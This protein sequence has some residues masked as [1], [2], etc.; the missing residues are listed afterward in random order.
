MILWFP[1]N[2]PFYRDSNAVWESALLL[3][4]YQFNQMKQYFL[5]L[6]F[7][8]LSIFGICQSKKN[9][10]QKAPSQKEM[11]AMMEEAMKGMSA[12]EKAQ[13]KKMVGGMMTDMQA[14]PAAAVVTFNDNKSLIPVRN[15][16]A[17]KSISSKVFSNED[18]INNTKLLYAKLIMKMPSAEKKLM[19]D[20]QGIA[21]SGTDVMAAAVTAF[22]QGHNEVAMGLAMKAVQSDAGNMN[23]QNNLAAICSQSGYPEIA[24][25]Y[26]RKL[27]TQFPSNS[28]VLNNLAYAWLN[29]GATD[30]AARIFKLAS[31]QN[32]N[33]PET[34]IG[35]G[36]IS[37]S[38]GDHEG[39]IVDYVK[40][41]ENAP[42]PFT[43]NLIKNRKAESRLNK[44]DFNRLKSRIAIHEYFR[45][46]WIKIPVLSDNIL[47]YSNDT[48]TKSGYLKM[49]ADLKL[50]IEQAAEA[51]NAELEALMEKDEE[52]LLQTMQKEMRQGLSMMSMPAVYVQKIIQA[53]I[54]KWTSDYS[55]ELQALK[56]EITKKKLT[57]LKTGNNDK[58]ADFDR[59]HN[60]FMA[61]AN[62]KI[63][64]FHDR[65]IEEMRMWLNAFCT[66]S[67]YIAGNS[68]NV[69][70]T[71]C[72]AWTAAISEIMES[73]VEEQYTFPQ[74]CV[75]QATPSP[76]VVNAP[77]IP[78][79]SCPAIVSMP[80]GLDEIKLS[81]QAI[82]FDANAFGIK[83]A[84]GTTIPNVTI[85]HSIGKS[86]ISEPG[87]YGDNYFKTG[88]GS[89]T[90]G[91][92]DD[93]TTDIDYLS[94]LETPDDL[95][96][97]DGSMLGGEKVR[98]AKGKARA[99]LTKKL[100]KKMMTV[101][102]PKS[103]PLKHTRKPDF[104]QEFALL[105]QSD[106]NV[107]GLIT[108]AELDQLKTSGL[109]IVIN[110]GLQAYNSPRPIILNLFN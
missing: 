11:D 44:M 49:F 76:L 101:N 24:I 56:S 93:V 53:H 66:W 43:E 89:V 14:Q 87:K 97:L 95:H 79:F 9:T 57:M 18:L 1:L 78:N 25:P 4:N 26:L 96:P 61:Y 3:H 85:S 106:L 7:T 33:N 52:A 34:E 37:E 105:D 38:K 82:N 31:V 109:E 73:A 54:V 100:I 29:L 71:Q 39:A 8:F 103:T 72:I 69:V 12:E 98:N 81:A 62:P 63:R 32:P 50:N 108:P 91:G 36:V 104:K 21:K 13:M 107:A 20:V 67:W 46:D 17:I 92:V 35:R 86:N 30:S 27:S 47:G 99:K 16:T 5:L 55:D 2:L 65:K 88:N 42:T 94:P 70:L 19:M 68:K 23:Y 80:L 58:C 59:K 77:S 15:T 28:T 51:S 10:A 45:K 102:C 110:N 40:A 6:A 60:E 83:Q 84:A 75:Q 22:L 74:S 48:R 41:F 64:E 90:A